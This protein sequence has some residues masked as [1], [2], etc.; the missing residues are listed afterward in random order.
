MPRKSAIT[1]TIAKV[2]QKEL[3]DA[4][5]AKLASK[6]GQAEPETLARGNTESLAKKERNWCFTWN[7]YT[8]SDID[9]LLDQLDQTSC[10]YK[11][12]EELGQNGTPHLQGIIA[13][14]SK[15]SFNSVKGLM[16]KAHIEKCIN[17]KASVKYCCKE[18]TRNGK[19]YSKGFDDDDNN[20]SKEKAYKYEDKYERQS[21]FKSGLKP[22]PWQQECIDII[23]T[24]PDPRKVYW[25]V[26]KNGNAGKSTVVDHFLCEYKG[27]VA[28]VEGRGADIKNLI[29][30]FVKNKHNGLLKLVVIDVPRTF[31]R[32]I[33]YD[34]IECIKNGHFM[35]TKY[36][37]SVCLFPTPH[38]IVFSNFEPDY[39][40]MSMDRWDVI[41][42]ETP[43]RQ[44]VTEPRKRKVNGGDGPV[45]PANQVE[46]VG[47][48]EP[49]D[50]ITGDFDA[51]N[52]LSRYGI[53][54]DIDDY[55][56]SDE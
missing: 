7:N 36:E 21:P 35:N 26:D 40:A 37:T 46:P 4:L 14:K 20:D 17:L 33:S 48:I 31:E 8:Q 6:Q 34:A 9:T 24:V 22:R 47:P 53:E 52:I 23:H 10:R 56:S 25:Y 18:A 44:P 27:H 11:F 45:L 32:N 19:V 39:N 49:R 16:P 28:C 54:S 51:N 15:I 38:V 5:N 12:Q 43:E 3:E 13:Y 50:N 29:C 1:K 41:E 2:D 30:E 55:S 42:L